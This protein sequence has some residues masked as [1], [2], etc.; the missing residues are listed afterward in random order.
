MTSYA[1]LMPAIKVM[2]SLLDDV[3]SLR[4]LYTSWL[5]VLP[6]GLLANRMLFCPFCRDT[7][8]GLLNGRLGA[9]RQFLFSFKELHDV[10]LYCRAGSNAFSIDYETVG[11]YITIQTSSDIHKLKYKN[12]FLIPFNLYHKSLFSWKSLFSTAESIT[13]TDRHLEW[14]VNSLRKQVNLCFLISDRKVFSRCS[15]VPC[16]FSSLCGRVVSKVTRPYRFALSTALWCLK[17]IILAMLSV[18]K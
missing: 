14:T 7:Y 11:T 9:N 1:R 18:L 15:F 16:L 3:N 17:K 2:I 10:L 12:S 13:C 6:V 8:D 5:M 4:L